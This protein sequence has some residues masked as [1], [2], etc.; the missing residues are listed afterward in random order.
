MNV[1]KFDKETKN[2]AVCIISDIMPG[3]NVAID[4]I[5][6]TPVSGDQITIGQSRHFPDYS[7]YQ[8]ASPVTTC[9]GI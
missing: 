9:D 5:V 7:W 4:T 1:S 2:G 8:H 3:V 6:L